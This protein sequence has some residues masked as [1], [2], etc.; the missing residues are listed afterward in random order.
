MVI[1]KSRFGLRLRAAGENP[2]AADSLG[3][4]VS[5]IRYIGVLISGAFAGLGGAW[6]AM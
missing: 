5:G 3:I 1:Y 2:E 6:L 4:N